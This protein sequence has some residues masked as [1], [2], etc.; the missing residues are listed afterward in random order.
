MYSISGTS[1]RF[2]IS[3]YEISS[4]YRTLPRNS[5]YNYIRRRTE[6]EAKIEENALKGVDEII[7]P[8]EISDSRISKVADL[9]EDIGILI[10]RMEY[11]YFGRSVAPEEVYERM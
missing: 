11:T 1:N 5:I 6:Y 7:E 10:D 8:F 2:R 3:L 9:H 4:G